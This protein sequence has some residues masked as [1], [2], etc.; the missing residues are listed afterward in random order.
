MLILT[1]ALSFGGNGESIAM[2]TSSISFPQDD[3]Q[4]DL[5]DLADDEAIS[6]STTR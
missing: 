4:R 1:V 2:V 3:V 6:I 5:A